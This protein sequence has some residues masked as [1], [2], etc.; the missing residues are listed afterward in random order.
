M[1]FAKLRIGALPQESKTLAPTPF[2]ANNK[3][4]NEE[5]KLSEGG[6]FAERSDD[7]RG[8]EV[9]IYRILNG[10]ESRTTIMVRNIPNKFK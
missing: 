8:N 7:R 4:G 1:E 10:E 9:D 3:E 5:A 6:S 2:D